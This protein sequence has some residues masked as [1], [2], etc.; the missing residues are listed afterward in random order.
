MRLKKA[1]VAIGLSGLLLNNGCIVFKKIDQSLDTFAE[2]LEKRR[3][4]HPESIL[5]RQGYIVYTGDADIQPIQTTIVTNIEK[6]VK[7]SYHAPENV[8]VEDTYLVLS[9]EFKD[10]LGE[11]F[12]EVKHRIYPAGFDLEKNTEGTVMSYTFK[13]GDI[14]PGRYLYEW[15][16][17]LPQDSNSGLL[18]S[19][20]RVFSSKSRILMKG[21]YQH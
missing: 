20:S 16:M 21:Y 9:R 15:I 14:E 12:H 5:N 3:E 6:I 1:I 19:I 2:K 7:F 13:S 18:K 11:P 17:V 10:V 4:K 8:N